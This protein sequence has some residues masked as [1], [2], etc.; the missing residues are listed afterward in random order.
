MK[1]KIWVR[2]M[3]HKKS[4]KK[5]LWEPKEDPDE[6]NVLNHVGCS[7]DKLHSSTTLTEV[8]PCFFLSRKANARVKHVKRGH[9]P[10]SSKLVVI[11]LF[12]GY[13]CCSVVIVLY[14][15]YLCCSVIIYVLC[16][17]CV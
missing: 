8:F 13:L 4:R 9:G 6:P 16:I 10:H 1:Y 11:V 7:S 14:C 5:N 2:L 12:C 3:Y 17:V 15:F